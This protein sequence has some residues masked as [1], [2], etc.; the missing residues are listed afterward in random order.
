MYQ[1]RLIRRERVENRVMAVEVDIESVTC[2]SQSLLYRQLFAGLG[3]F[4][5]RV[6]RISSDPL[7]HTVGLTRRCVDLWRL[8]RAL[9]LTTRCRSRS[10][11]F[12]ILHSSHD[13]VDSG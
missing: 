10:L 9:S 4:T 1:I 13:L 6:L 7:L 2:V 3:L 12:D 8:R 5:L 11:R